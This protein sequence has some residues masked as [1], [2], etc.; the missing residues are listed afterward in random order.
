MTKQ[1]EKEYVLQVNT[2][3]EVAYK[4]A[5]LLLP[6][7]FGGHNKDEFLAMYA[8]CLAKVKGN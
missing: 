3:E 7:P 1:N 4:M 8:D 5:K 2:P 6:E